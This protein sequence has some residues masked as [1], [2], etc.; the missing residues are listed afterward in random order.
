MISNL[1]FILPRPSSPSDP[2]WKG[3]A[4]PSS[5]LPS[6][7]SSL[8]MAGCASA[9]RG[10]FSSAVALGRSKGRA[11]PPASRQA[12][13]RVHRRCSSL[14]CKISSRGLSPLSLTANCTAARRA[15]PVPAGRLAKLHAMSPS[16]LLSPRELRKSPILPIFPSIYE[17]IFQLPIHA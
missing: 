17:L 14:A 13:P 7:P 16:F 11:H 1:Y 8:P 2:F 6:P 9:K 10:H 5:P 4:L 15:S 12:S 3:V